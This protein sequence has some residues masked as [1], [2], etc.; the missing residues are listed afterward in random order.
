MVRAS[1]T[2]GKHGDRYILSFYDTFNGVVLGQKLVGEKSN[3]IPVAQEMINHLDLEA[4]TVTC[5]ALNTQKN[6]AKKLIQA[7]AN[8]CLAVKEN[9]KGLYRDLQLAFLDVT[10]KATKEHSGSELGHG[11][12]ETR[13]IQVLPASGRLPKTVLKEW[14][15][16]EQGILIKAVNHIIRKKTGEQTI[17]TRYFISSLNFDHEKILEQTGR[18]VRRHWGVEND[19]H[20]TLDVDFNQDRIQCKNLNYLINRVALNK[21]ALAIINRYQKNTSKDQTPSKSRKKS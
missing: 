4:T 12:I 9:H 2:A 20:Y 11:R 6:F 15:G 19:L 10:E 1:S 14:M 13:T 3:E 8:Y 18:A 7:K 17:D 16:L 21:L 5:E